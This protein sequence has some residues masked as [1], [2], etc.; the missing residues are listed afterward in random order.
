MATRKNSKKLRVALFFSGR[1]TAYEHVAV[2]DDLYKRY[3]CTSFCSLN[4]TGTNPYLD[5]FFKKY[6]MGP[7]QIR[8]EKTAF[9]HWLQSIEKH[10]WTKPTNVYS[11]LYHNKKAFELI[12]PYMKGNNVNFDVVMLFRTDIDSKKPLI[13]VKPVAK[14]VYIPEGFNGGHPE[15]FL[16]H[17]K[18]T[19]EDY[20][21][22]A[23]L[24][25]GTYKSMRVYATIVDRIQEM[26]NNHK[27]VI[28]HER[29]I[30]NGLEL[31]GIHIK[32]FKYHYILHP[33]RHNSHYNLS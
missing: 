9:P 10:P 8:F 33:R 16:E 21:V 11:S 27:V 1:I 19:A 20:G 12:E 3:I 7:S 13:F 28:Q 31:Y 22:N 25:Y 24:A 29:L 5:T 23:T 17:V 4:K 30:K 32:L 26:Y 6:N 18:M 2:L 14:T 15:G